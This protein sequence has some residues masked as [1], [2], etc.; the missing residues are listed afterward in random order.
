MS[1]YETLLAEANLLPVGDRIQLIEAIWDTLPADS[2][3]TS[4]RSS[5]WQKFSGVRL[6]LTPG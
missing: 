4:D 3:S 2:P 6:N 5:G 1:N